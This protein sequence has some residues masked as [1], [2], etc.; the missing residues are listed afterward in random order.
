MERRRKQKNCFKRIVVTEI[1]YLNTLNRPQHK[2]QYLCL[3][4][5][6]YI[7]FYCIISFCLYDL[8]EMKKSEIVDSLNQRYY[9][10]FSFFW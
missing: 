10:N 7:C 5:A 8:N 2:K 1:Y 3:F 6:T 4:I 9:Y